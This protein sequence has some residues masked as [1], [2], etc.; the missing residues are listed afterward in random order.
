MKVLVTGADGLLGEGLIKEL[1]KKHDVYALV[2]VRSTRS[3][4]ENIK[5][6]KVDL[7]QLDTNGLPEDIDAV[8]YLAQSNLFR[9]F[10]ET[11]KDIFDVNVNAPVQLVSWAQRQGIKKFIYAS[12]GG[13]YDSSPHPIRESVQISIDKPKGFYLDSKVSA[14]TLLKNFAPLF[15]TFVV[16]RPFFMYGPGQNQSMLI[17]RLMQNI[18]LESPITLSG[19]NGIKINPIYVDD[20]AR[21]IEK[22]L[23]LEGEYTYNIAGNEIVSLRELTGLMAG[24]VKKNASYIINE[25]SQ[26]DLIADISQMKQ[27]LVSPSISLVQ[28]LECLYRAMQR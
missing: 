26:G 17:P 20:A 8:F 6:L 9:G 13:V 21:A 16:L 22:T 18:A 28:G 24:I 11:A 19:H 1:A 23:Y 27:D 25:L 14:E 12:S 4:H 15:E 2:S 10:P 3:K 5:V 7:T